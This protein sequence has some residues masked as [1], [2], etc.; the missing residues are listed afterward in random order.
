MDPVLQWQK[1]LS[2]VDERS[3]PYQQRSSFLQRRASRL[4]RCGEKYFA[5]LIGLQKSFKWVYVLI[6]LYLFSCII[7]SFQAAIFIERHMKAVGKIAF[8]SQQFQQVDAVSFATG[9]LFSCKKSYKLLRDVL[10][11][12]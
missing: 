10:C 12:Y 9:L 2:D 8:L 6:D 7:V 4:V 1:T 5:I 11:M 3:D